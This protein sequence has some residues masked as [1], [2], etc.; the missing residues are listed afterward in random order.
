VS[1]DFEVGSWPA[2]LYWANLFLPLQLL[3]NHS[4]GLYTQYKK[5]PQ[6]F[7]DVRCPIL[8]KTS[9]PLCR[10]ADWRGSKAG[11]NWKLN[12]SNMADNADIAQSQAR[13]YTHRRMQEVNSLCTD[14]GPIPAEYCIAGIPHNT[15]I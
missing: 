5:P 1:R 4:P 13:D 6:I 15:A 8:G 9:T 2:V 7:V 12:I 3:Q 10:L 11:L 14:S